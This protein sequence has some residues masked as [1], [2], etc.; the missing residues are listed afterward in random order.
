MAQVTK[1]F[2]VV[3]TSFRPGATDML[4]R[5][6]LGQPLELVREP[7]NKYDANAVMVC[8]GKRQIGYLPRGLAAE[9]APLMDKGIKVISRRA[10]DAREG[11][12]ELAYMPEVPNAVA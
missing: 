11:V 9:V 8:F 4:K 1:I 5:L 3:G 6:R 2:S 7:T 12:C 10:N